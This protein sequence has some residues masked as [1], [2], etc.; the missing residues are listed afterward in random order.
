[1][2]TIHAN[3]YDYP[4]LYDV[5][6]GW[7]AGVEV[8]FLEEGFR[9]HAAIPVRRVFEPFVGTGRIAIELARRGYDVTGW[10]VNPKAI[11]FARTRC[12]EAGV[13]VYL[14]VGDVCEWSSD[15]QFDAVVT[16]I[17]SFRYLLSPETAAAAVRAFYRGIQPGGV[18]IIGLDV[19]DKPV[20]LTQEERWT[21]ERDG[22]SVETAVF[23]MRKPGTLPGTSVARSVLHVT[24]AD[25]REYE[26]ITDDELRVYTR[27]S[28]LQ[29]LRDNGPFERCAVCDRRYDFDKPIQPE[30]AANDI[31]AVF[32]RA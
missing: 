4:H 17:D 20:E 9:R 19:G 10:D 31:V 26:I 5:A 28:F 27:E 13:H 11:A 23:D 1:M 29:L 24:E 25:G 2:E 3:W 22:T 30:D 6:F 7:D 15:R 8:S 18:L 14:Q 32:R 21:M 12:K 16:L